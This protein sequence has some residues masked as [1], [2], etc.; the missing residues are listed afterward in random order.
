MH[1]G[2]RLNAFYETH[3]RSD[4]GELIEL[5]RRL[6]AAISGQRAP[7]EPAALSNADRGAP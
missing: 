6:E 2:A 5:T 3:R 1:V 4:M 7:Q